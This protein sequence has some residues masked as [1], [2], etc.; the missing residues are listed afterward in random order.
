MKSNI[1]QE[2]K[3]YINNV[4][5]DNH[6]LYY[7]VEYILNEIESTFDLEVPFTLVRDMKYAL[8][9]AFDDIVVI[10]KE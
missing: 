7:S 3:G 9:S 5:F 4:P 8:Q 6:N 1:I 2:F 10:I